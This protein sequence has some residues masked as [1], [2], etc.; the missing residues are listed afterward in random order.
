KPRVRRGRPQCRVRHRQR[1]RARHGSPLLARPD[2]RTPRLPAHDRHRL[3]HSRPAA[4]LGRWP[5]NSLPLLSLLV[6]APWAGALILAA[7]PGIS[8]KTA[9]DTALV[10]SLSTL[11]LSLIA[12]AGFNPAASGYQFEEHHAWIR[13]LNVHYRLGLDG[14]SLLLVLLTAI[15]SPLA[16]AATARDARDTRLLG[17]LFLTLQGSALG[18]FLALDFFHWFIFWELSLVPAFFLIKLWGGPGAG[19]A[20]YQFVIYTIAGSAFMLLAFAALYASTGTLD[21]SELARLGASGG[22]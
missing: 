12:L 11:L 18:V 2:R 19:P 20:A 7:L 14:M 3:C 4:R 10:F 17:L 13:A 16:L 21:F 6:L 9:R 1:K 15:V 5:M 22:L 8:A